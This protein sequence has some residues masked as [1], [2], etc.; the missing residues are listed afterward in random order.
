MLPLFLILMIIILVIPWPLSKTLKKIWPIIGMLSAV[1]FGVLVV[2]KISGSD[3]NK[4]EIKALNETNKAS[5]GREVHLLGITVD[6]KDAF[7]EEYFGSEWIVENGALIWRPYDQKEGMPNSISA[8]FQPGTQVELKF[9]TNKWRGIAQVSCGMRNEKI[10]FYS[11]TDRSDQ[12]LTYSITVP[13][14]QKLEKSD[15]TAKDVI[16]ILLVV[17]VLLNFLYIAC[18]YLR[19]RNLPFNHSVYLDREMWIDML[20]VISAFMIILIHSSGNIYTKAFTQDEVLWYKMLWINAIPRFAVPCFLMITGVLTLGKEYDY[21]KVLYQK[22][23]RI[24]FPLLVWSSVYVMARKVL[25]QGNENL[26][27]ELLKIPFKRQD[28][29]LW[30]A[31]QLIWLYLGMPFWQRLYQHLSQ[32]LRWCF[33]IFS[34]VIPGVLTILG[35]LLLLDVPEYLP[36]ASSEPIIC[37][38]GVLFL[39]KL[40]YDMLYNSN[41][42]IVLGKGL[43]LASCGLGIMVAATIY[44]S[45]GKNEAVGIF[46]SEVR[47]PAILYGSGIF[48]IIASVKD[49]L[50]NIPG[51]LK[52]TIYSFSKVTL[53]VYLS[54]CLL[55]WLL[56]SM[57]VAGVYVNRDSGSIL[58]LLTC[59][60]VYYCITVIGCL[61]L[62]NLPGLKKLVL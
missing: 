42:A 4:I 27:E 29:S 48:L 46:F 22:V 21:G 28:G 17:L 52:L 11:D 44:V 25:W 54:H 57:V 50:Q 62:S 39:G 55:L 5:S 23:F 19:R 56:P 10:D 16:L 9:Q 36:F 43:L 3:D 24:M 41:K 31:Y 38:V 49:L 32:K 26:F 45:H 58:Q 13:N 7:P 14:I 40:L 1:M 20:K 47:L 61:L 33:V 37:Y 15:V 12:I 34:L 18:V 30:Y 8:H 35:E 2:M 6:G 53:G 59:V 60:V 51:V